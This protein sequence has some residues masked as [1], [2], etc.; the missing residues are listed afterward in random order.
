MDNINRNFVVLILAYLIVLI[1]ANGVNADGFGRAGGVTADGIR[2]DYVRGWF[3]GCDLPGKD[4]KNFIVE[5]GNYNICEDAC[6][7]DD[8][9]RAYTFVKPDMKK[10]RPYGRC[11][12]KYDLPEMVQK[13]GCISRYKIYS[14]I[15]EF[16]FTTKSPLPPAVIGGHYNY[17]INVS[18]G[19]K[20]VEFCPMRK[21]ASGAAPRCDNSPDQNFSMPHGLKL[22]KTGLISGQVE[23]GPGSDL[24]KC[25]EMYIPILIQ[26]RDNCPDAPRAIQGEF[27]I[28]I[29]N[30]VAPRN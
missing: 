27:W 2:W 21:D 23:C 3:G 6:A 24:S 17:Q 28:H 5:D 12:L 18:G 22:S 16:V 19:I 15:G 20:P 8:K 29:K 10:G 26:A 1:F 9:C 4:Y 13:E 25:K 14:C 30:P 11:Y 7:K